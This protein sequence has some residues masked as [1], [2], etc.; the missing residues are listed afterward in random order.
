M[1]TYFG[2]LGRSVYCL[3]FKKYPTAVYFLSVPT[4][5]HQYQQPLFPEHRFNV[6]PFPF[7]ETPSP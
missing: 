3:P 1:R 5:V 4:T 6:Y 7:Y 2:N